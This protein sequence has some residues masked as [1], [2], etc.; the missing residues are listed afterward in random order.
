MKKLQDEYLKY[1]ANWARAVRISEMA[2]EAAYLA[3]KSSVQNY[4]DILLCL[5]EGFLND[6]FLSPILL[7]VLDGD[8]YVCVT[9]LAVNAFELVKY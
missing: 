6:C 5:L 8:V 7:C 2:A 3:G 1:E 9:R 4:T